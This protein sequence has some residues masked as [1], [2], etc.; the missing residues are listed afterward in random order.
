MPRVDFYILTGRQAGSRLLLTCRL[1]EKAYRLGHTVYIHTASPEQ[2]QHLDELLWTFQQGSFV[3]HALYPD[4]D[5][6]VPP[7]L[8]G[9]QPEP[10]VNATLLINLSNE[11]PAFLERFERVAELVDQDE[12][13]LDI[14]RDKF[15]RYR[16]QG[17]ELHT[18]KLTGG[19]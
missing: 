17:C 9:W 14:S 12:K 15:R 4:T 1:A 16:A 5:H 8:I 7:V 10:Q 6:E 18:H 3:P 2:A 11:A 19:T 13:N